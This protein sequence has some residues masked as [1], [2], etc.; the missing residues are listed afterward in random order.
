VTHDNR[1]MQP[2]PSMSTARDGASKWDV[3]GIDT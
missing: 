2:F 3:D 1:R